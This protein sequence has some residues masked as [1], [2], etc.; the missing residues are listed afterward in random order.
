MTGHAAFESNAAH[1]HYL[2]W[3]KSNPR[4]DRPRDDDFKERIFPMEVAGR[5]VFVRLLEVG[6]FDEPMVRKKNEQTLGSQFQKTGSEFELKI[7]QDIAEKMF[8]GSTL[9]VYPLINPFDL[10]DLVIPFLSPGGFLLLLFTSSPH[11]LGV[12]ISGI[13]LLIAKAEKGSTIWAAPNL[14]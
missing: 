5:P 9:G 6:V 12:C 8:Q 3:L 13:S 2:E 11:H 4:E 14:I 1:L 7:L 10:P